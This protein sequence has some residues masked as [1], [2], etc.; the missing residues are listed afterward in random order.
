[1]DFISSLSCF[2]ARNFGFF[3]AGIWIDSPVRGFLPVFALVFAT[4]KVPKPAI[5]TSP[6]AFKVFDIIAIL[7]EVVNDARHRTKNSE[8]DIKFK[9]QGSEQILVKGD[10]NRIRQFQIPY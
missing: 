8:V 2:P 9:E 6:P 10:P 7:N 4:L 3:D 1:M 5:F